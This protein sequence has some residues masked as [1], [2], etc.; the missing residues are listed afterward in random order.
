[1]RNRAVVSLAPIQR[2]WR[3]TTR[4]TSS[5]WA[6]CEARAAAEFCRDF[7]PPSLLLG[8]DRRRSVPSSLVPSCVGA[9]SV[10]VALQLRRSRCGSAQLRQNRSADRLNHQRGD[11]YALVRV[12]GAR[13]AAARRSSTTQRARCACVRRNARRLTPYDAASSAVAA[14]PRCSHL[15]AVRR[16]SRCPLRCRGCRRPPAAQPVAIS[17][18]RGQNAFMHALW[19]RKGT[20]SR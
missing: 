13:S 20:C 9:V 18:D 14:A 1:M 7:Q 15:P 12:S 2:K 17:D 8:R 16:Q 19:L 6:E 5:V 4:A 11:P 10:P 3:R